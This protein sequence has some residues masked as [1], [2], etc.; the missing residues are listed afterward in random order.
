MSFVT[1]KR[2]E[3]EEALSEMPFEYMDITDQLHRVREVVYQLSTDKPS[4][5]IRIYSSIDVRTNQTRDIGNDA[6][7]IV[8]FNLTN[9]KPT[10]KTKR[11][12]RTE[13]A[14]TVY[15]R[16]RKRI[17]AILSNTPEA[18]ETNYDYVKA[19]LSQNSWSSF[20]TSL[21]KQVKANGSLSK[22]QLSYVLGREPNPHGKPTMETV[23]LQRD[24]KFYKKWKERNQGDD[25]ADDQRTFEQAR[26]DRVQLNDDSH[27]FVE[28]MVDGDV[29][30]SIAREVRQRRKPRLRSSHQTLGGTLNQEIP[31]TE[32]PT[33]TV[34][35]SEFANMPP[36][37][38]PMEFS[39]TNEY[40]YYGY[41][42]ELFN[43]VQTKVLPLATWE[44]NLVIGAATSAGKTVC[45]EFFIDD[46][47]ASGKKVIYLSPL[48]SL[49]QEKHDDWKVRYADKRIEIL[50]GDYTLTESSKKKLRNADIIVMTSEMMDSRT[51]RM[52]MENNYWLHEVGLVIVDEAHI[53]ATSRGHAVE[54]GI[55][56]FTSIN[57]TARILLLSAT[58][59][60]VN[61]LALWLEDI[62]DNP[63]QVVSSDW[64]P[65]ELDIEHFGYDVA[66]YSNGGMNY[67]ATQANKIN[68]AVDLA[69]T[70]M[71]E[72]YLIFVHDKTTGRRI[73]EK[74]NAPAS[75]DDLG[76]F[77]GEAS[78]TGNPAVFHN[79]DLNL[80][81]RLEIERGFE[82]RGFAEGVFDGTR[83]LVST[84][85]L[86]WG[87]NLPAR[88]VIVV[89]V[90]RGLSEVDEYDI[91]QMSG[92]AGR[93]GIDDKGF[94]KILLPTDNFGPWIDKITHPRPMRSVLNDRPTLAF[95][96]ISEIDTK[97]VESDTDLLAW[98]K[99]SFANMHEPMERQDATEIFQEL[100]DMEMISLEMYPRITVTGLGKVCSWLYFS[101]YDVRKWYEN[102]KLV[103]ENGSLETDNDLALA[104][105][106]SNVPSFSYGYVPKDCK[107]ENDDLIICLRN[108][109]INGFSDGCAAYFIGCLSAL[110][111]R[112]KA[113]IPTSAKTA[114]RSLTWDIRRINQA[115]TLIDKMFA[116]WGLENYWKIL[117]DRIK[118][119]I[120]G[121][122]IELVMIPGVGGK[123]ARR[124][125][126][127]GLRTI[128]KV[129]SKKG[130]E[131]LELIFPPIMAKKINRAAKVE[132]ENMNS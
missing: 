23:C 97:A 50:T 38:V 41:P 51:R 92:R 109:S 102:I 79:A 67:A 42:F 93:Y 52:Q 128:K 98:Y 28:T 40:Q 130:L 113:L 49:T 87:R 33:N 60:N 89:G 104:F 7:R 72:K 105:A 115:I 43:P 53:I 114:A 30:R 108:L 111:G 63:S 75:H 101:P 80:K 57:S 120:P 6:I 59:P 66:Y 124:M 68:G 56:R 34:V 36:E 132:L 70:K 24:P 90:H 69:R 37:A 99:R 22:K 78:D 129:A 112:D 45:A 19:I 121:D 94:V 131:R 48:K 61:E 39:A 25:E 103:H 12:N 100:V 73:V 15:Q 54:V 126:K 91:I 83:V 110:E 77:R 116:E 82:N 29:A 8:P 47:L 85:T 118:Y 13:G 84:S 9:N 31:R 65:V 18:G 32:R 96:A 64:R 20:A 16:I 27:A 81:D 2:H 26:S 95:H 46:T 86:A 21:L 11:V 106:I 74:L 55:M 127:M 17:D 122:M 44:T 123:R 10:G 125:Y 4:Q 3:F 5:V 119:G 71:D 62:N 107:V 14:T 58:M 1:I 35:L 88:N 76:H 117:P